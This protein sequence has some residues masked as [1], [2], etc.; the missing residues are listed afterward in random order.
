MVEQRA[1]LLDTA[2][3]FFSISFK[4]NVPDGQECIDHKVEYT[5][6]S[7]S[8]RAGKYNGLEIGYPTLDPIN[9]PANSN[10]GSAEKKG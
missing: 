6:G 7:G 4:V 9:P 3:P 8:F 5:L 1:L 10:S 2:D